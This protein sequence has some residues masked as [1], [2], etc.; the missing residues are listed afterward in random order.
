MVIKVPPRFH[1]LQILCNCMTCAVLCHRQ[2]L[3]TFSKACSKPRLNE[4]LEI[5]PHFGH[6]KIVPSKGTDYCNSY[7]YHLGYQLKCKL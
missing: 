2:Q 3:H 4:L 1:M 7:Q 6:L 5:A